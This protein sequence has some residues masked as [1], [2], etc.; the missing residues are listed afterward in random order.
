MLLVCPLTSRPDVYNA[1][2]WR[3]LAGNL[4]MLQDFGTGKPNIIVPTIFASALWSLHYEWWFYMLYFP[5]KT[6]VE[7]S[8]QSRLVGGLSISAALIY[9]FLPYAIPRLIMYFTI[10]WIGVEMGRSCMAKGRVVALDIR[11]SLGAAFAVSCILTIQCLREHTHLNM[12]VHPFLEPRHFIAA[13]AAVGTALI[14]QK[15]KW[16]GFNA[17]KVGVFIAPISYSLY[18]AHQPL[19]AEAHYLAWIGNPWVRYLGYAS[20]LLLFCIITELK[21]N[22]I[23]KVFALRLSQGNAP[24]SPPSS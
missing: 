8:N 10:W 16:K 24:P 11:T 19:L 12:G 17:L 9:I 1:E 15:A 2:F 22:P 6:R 23:L 20:I 7:E 3:I 14:W 4:A 18:I 5:I 13:I 21:I